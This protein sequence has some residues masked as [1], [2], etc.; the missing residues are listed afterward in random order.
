MKAKGLDRTDDERPLTY[1]APEL[2]SDAPSVSTGEPAAAAAGS[3][4]AK[5][6]PARTNPNRGSRGNRPSGNRPSG[7]RNKRKR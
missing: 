3:A 4:N 7:N 1:I 6:P 2:G 5:R